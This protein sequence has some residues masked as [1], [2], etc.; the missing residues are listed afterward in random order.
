[1]HIKAEK[2]AYHIFALY[3]EYDPVKVEFCRALKDTF[4]W[5]KFTFNSDQGLKR[6]VF[7]DPVI[8]Q[9]I[10]K[11]YPTAIVEPDVARSV[12]TSF[13]HYAAMETQQERVAVV[14]QKTD[15]NIE[16]NGIINSI[17]SWF[18]KNLSEYLEKK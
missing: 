16:I 1:M 15:T 12:A 14:Q 9:E 17:G 11:G 8:V 3:Y 7:S 5:D 6:W 10:I 18:M 4:G 13:K 2:S